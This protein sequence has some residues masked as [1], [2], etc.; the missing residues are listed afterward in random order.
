MGELHGNTGN[1]SPALAIA[2]RKVRLEKG[3]AGK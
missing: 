1:K 2:G 3:L